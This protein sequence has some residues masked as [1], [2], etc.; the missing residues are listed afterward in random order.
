M[1]G[2]LDYW[3]D[4]IIIVIKFINKLHFIKPIGSF[5]HFLTKHEA[6]QQTLNFKIQVKFLNY[7]SRIW[8][9]KN[10]KKLL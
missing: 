9:I 2:V 4:I 6:Q 7:F 10:L 5:Q 3:E 8:M 1:R